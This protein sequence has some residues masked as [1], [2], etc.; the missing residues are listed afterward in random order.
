MLSIGKV[1]SLRPFP[2]YLLLQWWSFSPEAYGTNA[3]TKELKIESVISDAEKEDSES[4]LGKYVNGLLDNFLRR[5]IQE[6][7]FYR[8]LWEAIANDRLILESEN[9]KAFAVY[10]ILIDS[11]I[12]YF[13]LG[14]S[15]EMSTEQLR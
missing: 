5:N 9:D 3:S 11:R 1:D 6:Y 13:R 15:I 4:R 8:G 14:T 12:P 2:A 10:Y 7:D